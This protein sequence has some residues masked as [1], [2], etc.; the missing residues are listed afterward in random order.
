MKICWRLRI[1][2]QL[3]DTICTLWA[4][5]VASFDDKNLLTTMSSE[6]F[7]E[8]KAYKVACFAQIIAVGFFLLPLFSLST[9]WN[10]C[11]LNQ[12]S[13]IKVV[14]FIV[15]QLWFF[16]LLTELSLFWIFLKLFFFSFIY[17]PFDFVLF[18]ISNMVLILLIIFF[19]L[20]LSHNILFH[21][22]IFPDWFFI[23][24]ISLFFYLFFYFFLSIRSSTFY[25]ICFLSKFG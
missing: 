25:F 17:F 6:M 5:R 13:W 9:H 7:N 14:S 10:L 3:A 18:F 4:R 23:L 20:I 24:L 11:Y 8:G 16:F 21:F 19:L 2:H 22:I 1:T 15:F 12:K